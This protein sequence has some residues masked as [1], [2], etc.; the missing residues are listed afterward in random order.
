MDP[1]FF[2][3]LTCSWLCEMTEK[4]GAVVGPVERRVLLSL[5]V[6]KFFVPLPVKVFAPSTV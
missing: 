3:E 1:F 4:T 2:V 6:P 5:S